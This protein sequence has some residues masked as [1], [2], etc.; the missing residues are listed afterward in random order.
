MYLDFSIRGLSPAGVLFATQAHVN[1][2]GTMHGSVSSVYLPL[3]FQAMEP[4]E[5]S[6]SQRKV[7]RIQKR[8]D[9]VV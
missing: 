6:S 2:R 9:V 5:L 7:V 3:C 8:D 4:H 1:L